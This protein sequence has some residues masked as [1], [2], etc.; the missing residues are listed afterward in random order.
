MRILIIDD[1]SP[2]DSGHIAARLA[3]EDDRVQVRQH[4]ENMGHIAT[5]DEGLLEW[6]EGRYSILLSA[7]D[8]LAPG[9][10][11]RATG[12]LDANP[13]VGFVYGHV[14]RWVDGECK[15]APR[16]QSNG[17]NVWPG[18]DWLRKVCRLGHSVVSSP[19]VVVRTSTQR[20]MAVTD[21]N[22]HTPGIPRCG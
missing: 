1:A 15:P 3:A 9:S 7:D 2:D 16:I 17:V 19:E 6:A 22:Y 5:S 11:A 21:Q 14:V 10:V 13:S 20:K 18:F 4:A 8:L 12:V